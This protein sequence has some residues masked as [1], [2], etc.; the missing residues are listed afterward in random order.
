M[1]VASVICLVVASAGFL[2]LVGHVW[3]G[4]CLVKDINFKA[5]RPRQGRI[6]KKKRH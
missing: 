2:V 4:G 6:C 3:R 5:K 1:D